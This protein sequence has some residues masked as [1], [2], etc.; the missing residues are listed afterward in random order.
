MRRHP[1]EF[2][3]FVPLREAD[4]EDFDAYLRRMGREGEWVEGET[5]VIAVARVYNVNIYLWGYDE[6]HDYVY[7]VPA[8]N[9]ETRDIHLAHYHDVH[10]RAVERAV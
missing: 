4:G 3:A 5:E 1:G 6:R 8:P 2:A 10:Y 7:K 9:L